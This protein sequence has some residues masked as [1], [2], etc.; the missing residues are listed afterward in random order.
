MLCSF[1]DQVG[2]NAVA[3]QTPSSPP[4]PGVFC[5]QTCVVAVPPLVTTMVLTTCGALLC[6]VPAV[7]WCLVRREA[8]AGGPSSQPVLEQAARKEWTPGGPPNAVRG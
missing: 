2:G 7:P 8:W 5:G 6:L 4:L 3:V 1:A